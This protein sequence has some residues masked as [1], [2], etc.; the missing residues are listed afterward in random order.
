MKPDHFAQGQ[1]EHA[2]GKRLGQV[3]GGGAGQAGDVRE[4]L[5]AGVAQELA[6]A[7]D[8]AFEAGE[9][10]LQT[11]ELE[12]FELIAGHHL[13]APVQDLHSQISLYPLPR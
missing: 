8:V 4:R 7:A 9:E 13:V 6:I 10:R 11:F 5:D 12:L 3:F 1:R 2:V